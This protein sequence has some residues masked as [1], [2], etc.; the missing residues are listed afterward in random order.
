M[1]ANSDL[2]HVIYSKSFEN[3]VDVKKDK[4]IV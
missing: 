3:D 1:K 4:E 2:T